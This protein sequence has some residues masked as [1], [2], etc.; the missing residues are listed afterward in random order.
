YAGPPRNRGSV[1]RPPAADRPAA[2]TVAVDRTSSCY[3]IVPRVGPDDRRLAPQPAPRGRELRF[4]MIRAGGAAITPCASRLE[5]RLREMLATLD[6]QH[7]VHPPD[8]L[9]HLLQVRQVLHLD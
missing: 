1:P 8:R 4:L 5:I 6:R 2:G 7:P 9:H 3:G